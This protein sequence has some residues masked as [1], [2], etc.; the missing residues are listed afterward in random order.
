MLSLGEHIL[1]SYAHILNADRTILKLNSALEKFGYKFLWIDA[2]EFEKNFSE[3]F[4]VPKSNDRPLTIMI[5]REFKGIS[6]ELHNALIH[7]QILG[8][9]FLHMEYPGIILLQKMANFKISGDTMDFMIENREFSNFYPFV[10]D[11]LLQMRLH[12]IGEI[13]C[14]QLFHISSV[15]R[16]ISLRKRE[17][18]IGSH[19]DYALTDEEGEQLSKKL[20]AKYK[21]NT[22]TELA[23]KNFNVVYDLP[24]GRIRFITLMTCLE[25]LFNLGKDQ[26]AHTI[27]RHL[28]I[29]LSDNR[30]QFKENYSKIKKLYNMR[31]SIVHGGD[32]KGDII[33]DYLE[34][35]NKVRAAINFCNV[36]DLT[37][38]KLFEDFNSR[39]Y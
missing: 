25:S 32:Y 1:E 17:I 20:V 11:L 28:S 34:L 21:S 8:P 16:Q 6:H 7:T 10:Q 37:K 12:K 31:N 26:I 33:Q 29:I 18:E 13:R 24:D 38:E 36:P 15:S 3:I 35:S 23:L 9:M 30:Q 19:G 4:N 27:A 5:G 2:S 39:G 14:S 22:L